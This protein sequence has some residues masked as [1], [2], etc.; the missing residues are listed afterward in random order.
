MWWEHILMARTKFRDSRMVLGRRKEGRRRLRTNDP[1]ATGF[2]SRECYDD[3]GKSSIIWPGC[4]D[5]QSY[6]LHL[7]GKA[8]A[9]SFAAMTALDPRDSGPPDGEAMPGKCRS[10]LSRHEIGGTPAIR[11]QSWLINRGVCHEKCKPKPESP[12]TAKCATVV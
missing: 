4:T 2:R 11:S 5:F 9:S 10:V 1:L 8:V 7:T 12:S 3:R 6:P